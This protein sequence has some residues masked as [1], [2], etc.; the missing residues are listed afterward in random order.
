MPTIR[1][2]DFGAVPGKD[3]TEA[4]RKMFAAVDKGLRRDAGGGVPGWQRR[5][6]SSPAAT[7]CRAA[8]CGRP[9]S[10][11]G[12]DDPRHRQ[13][14]VGDR[15]DGPGAAPGQPGPVDGRPLVL[16]A[17][18]GRRTRRRATCTRRAPAPARTGAGRTANGAVPL[19]VRHRSRRTREQQHQLGDALHRL[20]HQRRLR[21]GLPVVRHDP[22]PRAAGPVPQPLV[23]RLQGR[24]RP[25]GLPAFRQGRVHPRRRRQLHHQGPA[26]RRRGSAGSSTSRRPGTAT[27]CSTSPSARCASSSATPEPGHPVP[28]GGARRLRRL[29][30]HGDGLPEAQ[31]RPGRPRVH[32]PRRRRLPA[33]RPR[34]QARLP[35]HA[36]NPRRRVVY[37]AC[38][39]KNNRTAASFLVI[40]GSGAS[41]APPIT[42]TNDADGIT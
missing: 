25:R 41:A 37:D 31:R 4:F 10:G 38:T 5:R 23:Q 29:L 11:A 9:G 8:S 21:Q 20:P 13:A 42:H 26:A 2:E 6:S 17:A 12:A 19:A 35:P 3:A 16:T 30:R 1:P 15:D 18:S 36:A 14:G 24:V 27:P 32:Q 34:R 28:V 39:R 22:G 40:D 7:A 33:L